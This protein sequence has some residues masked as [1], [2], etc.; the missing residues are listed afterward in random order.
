MK[1][2]EISIYFAPYHSEPGRHLAGSRGRFR[3]IEEAILNSEWPYDNGDDPSFYAY[4]HGGRLTW[5]VCRQKVRNAIPEGSIVVFI[6]FTQTGDTVLYRMSA[7]ATVEKRLDRRRLFSDA[8]FI[9]A[10]YLNILIRPENGGWRYDEEDRPQRGRA[11]HSDWLWRMAVHGRTTEAF[12]QQYARLGGWFAD[13]EV[14]I[15]D[16]YILFSSL[17][18]DTYVASNPPQVAV[19]FV[20]GNGEEEE[21]TNSELQRLTLGVAAGFRRNPRDSLRVKNSSHCNVHVELPFKMPA[22][23]A[24][25]WRNRLITTLKQVD[26]PLRPGK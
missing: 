25:K 6:A 18:S 26:Q 20:Q 17:P 10:D 14:P 21:W 4:R 23:E 1:A 24:A 9:P 3:V 19:A 8:R 7:V 2:S 12:N 22:I 15:A 11:R 13:G 5:G 16:N